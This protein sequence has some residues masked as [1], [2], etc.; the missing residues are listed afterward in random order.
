MH[1]ESTGIV[2]VSKTQKSRGGTEATVAE[3]RG[4][5]PGR[6]SVARVAAGQL[7]IISNYTLGRTFYCQL[8]LLM[9]LCVESCW[10]CVRLCVCFVCVICCM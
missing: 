7:D 4:G 8:S 2:A 3:A 6:R 1:I 10:V 5:G 9:S